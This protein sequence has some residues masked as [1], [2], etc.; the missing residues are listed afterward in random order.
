[1]TYPNFLDPKRLGRIAT[2]DYVSLSEDL[3]VDIG[4]VLDETVNDLELIINGTNGVLPSRL[5]IKFERHWVAFNNVVGTQDTY[6][7]AYVICSTAT[8]AVH[9]A[10]LLNYCSVQAP[11]TY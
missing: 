1:M 4:T 2:E 3:L 11:T 8:I 5:N 7:T 10:Y 6:F 9:L